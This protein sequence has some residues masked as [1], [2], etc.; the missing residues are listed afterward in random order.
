M[1][2]TKLAKGNDGRNIKACDAYGFEMHQSFMTE[3]CSPFEEKFNRSCMKL[4]AILFKFQRTKIAIESKRS[5]LWC[6]EFIT[7]N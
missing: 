5:N 3:V 6:T 1:L 7:F 4:E 2:G